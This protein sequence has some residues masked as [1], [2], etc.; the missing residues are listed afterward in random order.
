LQ[1]V[2]S[3]MVIGVLGFAGGAILIVLQ[4]PPQGT[5]LSYVAVGFGAL[6]VILHAVVP[7]FV[8]RAALANQPVGSG[9]ESLLRVYFTRTIV[10]AALLEGGAFMSLAAVMI[11]HQRWVLGVAAVLLVLMVMQFPSR[12]RIEQWVETRMMEREQGA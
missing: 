7:A 12:T 10:A 4:K 5:T 6:T 2:V 9:A 11:E 3:A 8:E 1:I